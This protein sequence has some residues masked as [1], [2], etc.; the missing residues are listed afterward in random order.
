MSNVNLKSS[1]I[2]NIQT[3]RLLYFGE[4]YGESLEQFSTSPC[5][6]ELAEGMTGLIK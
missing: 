1:D 5:H 4:C 3:E 6:P 2:G